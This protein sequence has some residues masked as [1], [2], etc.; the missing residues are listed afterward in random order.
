[1]GNS[2]RADR[3][4]SDE[5][6]IAPMRLRHLRQVCAIDAKVYPRPWSLAMYRQE[7]GLTE[8]RHYVIAQ[9]QRTVVGYAGIMYIGDEGHVTTVAVDPDHQA[10]GVATRLMSDLCHHAIRHRTTALTLEVRVS[11]NRAIALYRRFGF[12]PAG[13]R[14]NYYTD[15]NEDALIMWAHDVNQPAYR[16][17]L[18]E[19]DAAAM[20]R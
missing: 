16:E 20:V 3:A 11:N 6:A 1:L 17:R 19:I 5:V 13:V 7:L 18:A 14:K 10:R 4:V 12:A 8:S 15:V 2:R 9:Q